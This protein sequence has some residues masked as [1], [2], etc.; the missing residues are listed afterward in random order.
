MEYSTHTHT[1]TGILLSH[2][3]EWN[4]AICSNM[5][6]PRD[7]HPKWRQRITNTISHHSYVESKKIKRTN[8]LIYQTETHR[9][10]KQ[11]YGYQ[12]GKGGEG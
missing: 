8:E 10:R 9:N 4:H 7:D 6:G 1:H 2:K 11:T 3:K 12:R 5:D